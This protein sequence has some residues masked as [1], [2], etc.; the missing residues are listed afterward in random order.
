[1]KVRKPNAYICD[2]LLTY[3]H[4]AMHLCLTI[5]GSIYLNPLSTSSFWISTTSYSVLPCSFLLVRKPYFS[6]DITNVCMVC[7]FTCIFP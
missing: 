4:R 5:P 2:G 1:M 3:L 6:N 7:L